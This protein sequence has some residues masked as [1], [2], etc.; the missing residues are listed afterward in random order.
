MPAE[1]R[2]ILENKTTLCCKDHKTEFCVDKH[3]SFC[4][5]GLKKRD[6]FLNNNNLRLMQMCVTKNCLKLRQYKAHKIL[7]LFW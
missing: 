5:L 4:F 6:F 1:T 2:W 3:H 7:Y